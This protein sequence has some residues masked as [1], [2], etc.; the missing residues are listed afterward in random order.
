MKREQEDKK[1][2]KKWRSINLGLYFLRFVSYYN[3]RK[4]V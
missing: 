4:T 3:N 1:E 2:E